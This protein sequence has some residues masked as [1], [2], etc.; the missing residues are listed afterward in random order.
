M[1]MT[2]SELRSLLQTLAASIATQGTALSEL[3]SRITELSPR[4][5]A[6]VPT[7]QTTETNHVAVRSIERSFHETHTHR[8]LLRTVQRHS[9]DFPAPCSFAAAAPAQ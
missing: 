2:G 9:W 7:L 1:P 4:I 5:T 3:S 8:I 6:G